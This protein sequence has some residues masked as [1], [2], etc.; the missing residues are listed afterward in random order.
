MRLRI[1]P[2]REGDNRPTTQVQL[3]QNR[4][5]GRRQTERSA[6]LC[7]AISVC[8][9]YLLGNPI[10]PMTFRSSTSPRVSVYRHLRIHSRL[11]CWSVCTPQP[12][13]IIRRWTLNPSD[14]DQAMGL[15]TVAPGATVQTGNHHSW[16][17]AFAI[18]HPR[19]ADGCGLP[20]MRT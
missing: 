9:L 20:T 3:H 14:T 8:M 19:P 18:I 16:N 15:W 17:S 13:S 5:F 2:W 12:F 7:R 10:R 1:T 11:P 4:D 6:P